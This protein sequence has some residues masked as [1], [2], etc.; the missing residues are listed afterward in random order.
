[1]GCGV[2]DSVIVSI[3]IDVG[4]GGGIELL[5]T[6]SVDEG[7]VILGVGAAV[8]V[9][10]AVVDVIATVVVVGIVVVVVVVVVETATLEQGIV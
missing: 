1:M 3:S 8:V 9:V 6:I 10:S 2:T 4:L 7:L 5:D